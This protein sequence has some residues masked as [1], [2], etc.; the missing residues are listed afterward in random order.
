MTS[1]SRWCSSL[2]SVLV[3]VCLAAVA[4]GQIVVNSA[5]RSISVNSA[6][7]SDSATFTST[8]P[9]ERTL[10]IAAGTCTIVSDASPLG[11]TCDFTFNVGSPPANALPGAEVF[12]S[13][14]ITIPQDVQLTYSRL[15]NNASSNFSFTGPGINISGGTPPGVFFVS[16][17]TYTMQFSATVTAP[18]S[19]QAALSLQ[20]ATINPP[21]TAFTYQGKLEN[22]S[23]P[24]PPAI[25]VQ[26][27]F[28]TAEVGG[29]QVPGTIIK[30]VSNVPV[31]PS[32]VF[33]ALLDP[34][35]DLPSTPVWMFMGVRPVGAQFFTFFNQKQRISP[36]PK[37]RRAA[38]ADTA[39]DADFAGVAATANLA[40]GV[41][42]QQRITIR[43]DAGESATSPGLW[44]A[45]PVVSPFLRAFIGMRDSDRVGF[46]GDVSGWS[47]VMNTSNGFLGVGTDSPQFNLQLSGA[48][49]TQ[50]AI[51]STSNGGRTWSLQ[52][53]A[54]TYGAGSPLNGAF[55]IVDRTSNQLRMLIDSSGNVGIGTAAPQ[56]KLQVFGGGVRADSFTFNTP[57]ASSVTI[58]ETAWRSRS[59]A[60]TNIGLGAGGVGLAAG[61]SFGLVAEIPLPL[62]A[63]ITGVT[64]FVVDNDAAVSLRAILQQFP[65]ASSGFINL[66]VPALSVGPSTATATLSLSPSFQ[67]TTTAGNTYQIQ[68]APINGN[69]TNN[70]FVRGAT[71]TYTMP[72]PAQ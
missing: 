40:L 49:D 10:T 44:L 20:F 34:G 64:V 41:D 28:W 70:L 47:L 24:V 51:T 55:Q 14:N 56:S 60:A 36:A 29:T 1:I 4:P 5:S 58:G 39:L 54:G 23:G 6:F 66:S 21:D 32:G 59:G 2:V 16:A 30:T 45:S 53:S 19:G 3:V 11:L 18:A 65:L 7:G 25:D 72:R 37:A 63:T 12:Y 9:W 52:S 31:A 68:V 50:L 69:W 22:G 8:G 62:G 17:G 48:T 26:Y 38:I 43:G 42:A 46:Y 15:V 71:I 13:A 57:V 61:D 27:S 67:V 35:I 33:T